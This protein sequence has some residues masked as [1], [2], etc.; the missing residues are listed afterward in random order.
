MALEQFFNRVF[1]SV[2]TTSATEEIIRHL[3]IDKLEESDKESR[4]S[5]QRL[6]DW[7]NKNTDAILVHLE[8]AAK[9]SFDAE[10][11]KNWQWPLLNGVPR[12]I[13]R[14]ALA[15]KQAPNR[16][17]YQG[18]GKDKKEI[19]TDSPIYELVY[20]NTGM[21]KKIDINK[22]F[23]EMDR[24][25]YLFNTL[26][27]EVVPR[28]GAID[29]DIRLKPQTIVVQD[30]EDCL[31]YNKIAFEYSLMDADTL[32]P[33]NG[34]V[35]WSK[36]FYAMRLS[37]HEWIGIANAEGLNPYG[38]I[39]VVVIRK[40][41]QD[42][43]W[44]SCG[45]DLVDGF[46]KMNIQFSQTWET[47]FMQT[48]GVPVGINLH[49]KPEEKLHISPKIP[50]TVEDVGVDEVPPSL[51]FVKPENDIDKLQ[52]LVNFYLKALGNSEGLPPGAWSMEE[53]PESG[54]AKFMNNIESIENRED[55]IQAWVKI[56]QEMFDVSRTIHNYYAKEWGM[57]EIPDDITLEVSF[58]P[59]KIPESPIE[60]TTR[61][62][63]AKAAGLT[64]PVRYYMEEHGMDREKAMD[65]VAEIQ[66]E[67]ELTQPKEP[68]PLE[69]E[70]K[71]N[72][73]KE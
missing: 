51:T 9:K 34:W 20:G 53:I 8:E 24:Y 43:Y 36:D 46:E 29:W 41:E 37:N 22:K 23:K 13:K 50:V 11:I 6:L 14:N 31:T 18:I 63:A 1:R 42:D 10:E 33:Y 48:F 16:K 71:D 47:A 5:A 67:N 2:V 65:L 21:F 26:H 61:Y 15:Y 69:Y 38:I 30:P 62:V 35:Y 49:L 60:K 27:V 56:E 66:E 59:V 55:G 28:K 40:L 64:S 72:E 32:T 3:W 68:I 52:D 12:M 44:G 73:D 57:K 54:F 58:P 7:Y 45:S 70:E 25:S 19:E 39:P 4:I 17:L